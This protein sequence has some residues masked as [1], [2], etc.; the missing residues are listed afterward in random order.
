MYFTR[1]SI[2]KFDA[3]II[4]RK[5]WLYYI[6]L[7]LISLNTYLRIVQDYNSTINYQIYQ[8][9]KKKNPPIWWQKQQSNSYSIYI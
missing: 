7:Y 9:K 6:H 8:A 5:N 2:Y 1:Y 3:L 4:F